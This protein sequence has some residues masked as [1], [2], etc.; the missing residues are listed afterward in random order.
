MHWPALGPRPRWTAGH[1]GHSRNGV[2]HVR[3]SYDKSRDRASVRR[4]EVDVAT[5]A[6][7]LMNLSLSG[8]CVGLQK[9]E[10]HNDVTGKGRSPK[11]RSCRSSIILFKEEGSLR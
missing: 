3:N 9:E 7:G 8:T 5:L 4:G 2:A 10:A 1:D 11:V 6:R